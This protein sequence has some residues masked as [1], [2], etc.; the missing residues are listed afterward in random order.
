M[1]AE[2]AARD[3]AAPLVGPTNPIQPKLLYSKQEAAKMLS[4]SAR[5]VDNL[6]TNGKLVTRRIGSRVLIPYSSL[7]QCAKRDHSTQKRVQ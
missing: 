2:I 6:I 7:V 4:G 3:M 5:T 1:N